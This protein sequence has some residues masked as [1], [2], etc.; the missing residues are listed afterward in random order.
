MK[1]GKPI[2][3]PEA[4]ALL[5]GRV[6]KPRTKPKL[7]VKPDRGVL[8]VAEQRA[9][10]RWHKPL[11]AILAEALAV[12][13]ALLDRLDLGV[14]GPNMEGKEQYQIVLNGLYHA[15]QQQQE[16]LEMFGEVDWSEGE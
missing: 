11:P 10:I 9:L 3:S 14:Y 8:S 15:T 16:A 2:R 1:I 13:Q 5:L 7:R 6:P 12:N 4:Q